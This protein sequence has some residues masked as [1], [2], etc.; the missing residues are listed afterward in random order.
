MRLFLRFI[1]WGVSF[2]SFASVLYTSQTVI[3]T[4]EYMHIYYTYNIHS[5][6]MHVAI[7][8]GCSSRY[9]LYNDLTRIVDPNISTKRRLALFIPVI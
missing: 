2:Y 7:K 5:I 6:Y 1:G 8:A 4:L 9:I 3:F